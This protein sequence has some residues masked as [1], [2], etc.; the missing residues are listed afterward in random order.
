VG[1]LFGGISADERDGALVRAY[2]AAGRTLDDLPYTPEFDRIYAQA[3]G[4]ET[5]ESRRGAF[6]RLHTLRKAGRLARMGR[7]LGESIKVTPAEEDALTRL[8]VA[9]VGTL[10]QRDQL[11]FTPGFDE[12]VQAFN[13]Q[14][15]RDLSPHAVWRLLA[16]IAK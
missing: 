1:G 9:R 15:G 12:L 13:A 16:K 11:I 8:V 7:A 2:E 3:G 5:W 6:H 14:S 4:D 10:G